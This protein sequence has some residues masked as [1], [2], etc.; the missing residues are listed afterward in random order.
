MRDFNNTL[1]MR[2]YVTSLICGLERYS[3]TMR[4][5]WYQFLDVC[6]C[7]AKYAFANIFYVYIF[8]ITLFFFRIFLFS[9][10]SWSSLFDWVTV[11]LIAFNDIINTRLVLNEINLST[12][13]TFHWLDNWDQKVVFYFHHS[14]KN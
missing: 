6:F 4:E 8:P 11:N 1:L 7:I 14:C 9:I 12:N 13:F 5:P 2:K 10:P 3:A